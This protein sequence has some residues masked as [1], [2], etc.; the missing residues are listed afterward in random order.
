MDFTS[1]FPY[2]ANGSIAIVVVIL[3]LAGVLV[4]GWMYKDLKKENAELKR[5][6][7]SERTRGDAAVEAARTSRDVLLSLRGRLGGD[8]STDDLE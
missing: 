6:L 8:R 1:L 7:G 5:A 4:P 2:I 3:I